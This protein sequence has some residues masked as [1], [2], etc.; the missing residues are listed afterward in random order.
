MGVSDEESICYI[1]GKL[2]CGL[3]K[4]FSLFYLACGCLTAWKTKGRNPALILNTQIT[5]ADFQNLNA[6]ITTVSVSSNR[7]Q[8]KCGT[9]KDLV[10]S[11][12]ASLDGVEI[13]FFFTKTKEMRNAR[14]GSES[15]S[16]Q[17]SYNRKKE[18]NMK[19]LQRSN[20]GYLKQDE[21]V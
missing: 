13:R 10:Q 17:I 4:K 19:R 2:M 18:L 7:C 16:C 9:K 20:C 6:L 5:S 14:S 3:N 21:I 12:K 11:T 1:Y 8:K 15:S